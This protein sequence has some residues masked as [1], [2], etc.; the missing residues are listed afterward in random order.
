MSAL[1]KLSMF[2]RVSG[3]L[4]QNSPLS[5]QR[6]EP[7]PGPQGCGSSDRSQPAGDVRRSA[8]FQPIP[9]FTMHQLPRWS[10]RGICTFKA[11]NDTG[12]LPRCVPLPV[13]H[14]P[15]IDAQDGYNQTNQAHDALIVQK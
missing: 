11:T 3:L 1:F 13:F 10:C 4:V 5:L 7:S 9:L 6:V 15:V 2:I 8:L 12:S 14:A